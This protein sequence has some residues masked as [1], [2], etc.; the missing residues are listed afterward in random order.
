LWARQGSSPELRRLLEALRASR[1]RGAEDADDGGGLGRVA[2]VGTGPCS[3]L[4]GVKARSPEL[5]ETTA[6]P[7]KHTLRRETGE[8][9]QPKKLAA[10]FV[11]LNIYIYIYESKQKRRPVR[12]RRAHRT[13][14]SV[15]SCAIPQLRTCRAIRSTKTPCERAHIKS[16]YRTRPSISGS[17]RNKPKTWLKM[18]GNQ[19]LV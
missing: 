8:L 10:F 9:V 12:P 18:E 15:V 19:N 4:A 17:Q 2:F 5:R 7:C 3:N 14:R 6:A 11:L 1:G 13:P 16:L